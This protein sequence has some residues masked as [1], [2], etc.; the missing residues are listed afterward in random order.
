KQIENFTAKSVH[1]G[2]NTD[3]QILQHG[4]QKDNATSIF[5]AIGNSENGA[6]KANAEQESRVLMLSEKARGD[7]SPILLI[8]EDD[9]RAGHAASVGREDPMQLDYV[10]R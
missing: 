8:D 3:A 1:I 6:T 9:V 5:N 4:R 7:A 2:L 10:M